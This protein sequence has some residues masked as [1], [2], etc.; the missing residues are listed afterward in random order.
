M[1]A[2]QHEVIDNP[3]GAH[4]A[5]LL[6][7]AGQASLPG[8]ARERLN[9]AIGVWVPEL[10]V[11]VIDAGHPALVGLDDTSY[12]EMI[13]RAAWHEWGHA[14]SMARATADDVL[15]GERLLG[16]APSGI[17]ETIRRAGYL[18]GEFTHELVAETYALL[19]ARRRRGGTG[20]PGWLHNDIWA[21]IRRVCGWNQ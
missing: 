3:L 5:E 14:L 4:L 18:R 15:D 20:K 17:A 7:S 9:R 1:G 13:V 16:L 8:S 2:A 10:R 21:L 12:E 6:A 19:M 11:V